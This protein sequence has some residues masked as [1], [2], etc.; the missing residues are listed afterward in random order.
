MTPDERTERLGHEVSGALGPD[1]VSQ[2]AIDRYGHAHDA[3]HY[4]LIPHTVVTPGN[5]DDVAELLRTCDRLGVPLTFRSAGTSLSGQ[6]ITDGVLA[7]VRHAFRGVEVLDDGRRVRVQPGTTVASVN[8]R[9]SPY[10]YRLGPDPASE[11]ACTIGGVVANNSSGMQCGTAFNTYSTLESMV[12]VLPTG[13]VI[14][15]SAPDA[16]RHLAQAEPELHDGLQ[17]LRRRIMDNPESVAM[18]RQQFSMKNTMGYGLN[19]F[20]DYAEP[21]DILVHLMI[22]SEGTL[23]FIAEATFRTV[24]VLPHVATALL[25]FDELNAATAAVPELVETGTVTAELLDAASL[26]V[27]QQDPACPAV[28]SDLDVQHHAALLVEY[29]G[30]SPEELE[31]RRRDAAPRLDDLPLATPYQLTTDP[32][33][34]AGLWRTRKGLYSAVA[35]ARPSGTSALLEDVVVPVDR[36]GATCHALTDLFDQHGYEQSVIFGHARDGNV[37]FLINE[38]FDD[39]TAMRRYEAFTEEFVAL[40]LSESGSLKAEHGTGRIMAPFVRRQFGDELY[41]VMWSLKRLVDPRGLLNPAS[42]LSDD[43][44]SYLRDLKTAEPVEQEVDRCVECGYCEPVCPSRNLTTT[45]RQRIVLRREIAAAERRGETALADELR[46]D[47]EYDGVQSCAV[48]GMCETACP[49]RINT[50]DLVQRLRAENTTA[51]EERLW[52]AAASGWR[53]AS[54]GGSHA[55]STADT[56]PA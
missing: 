18:L 14:D 55:L 43:P 16:S 46:R 51:L 27:S 38:R 37:H 41:D 42:V 40:V 44:R 48:D 8:A 15:S 5:T 2:R 49:V 52:S 35:W 56:L 29:Q 25:V 17:R 20:L 45:P 54:R 10:G 39:T 6:A 12:L 13:T 47:Y 19:A 32:G 4:L 36:L 31:H 53:A 7:D 34:R 33:N 22:G 28:I 1:A 50:G 3:S 9:L 11:S 26:R 23:G 30:A 24:E 21:L